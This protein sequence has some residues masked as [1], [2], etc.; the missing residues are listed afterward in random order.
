MR[1]CVVS[2]LM[3]LLVASVLS[4]GEL[5][6]VQMKDEVMVGDSALVLNGMGV[7]KKL[8]IKVYVAGLYLEERTGE[9]SQAVESEQAKQVVMHF[10]TDRATKEK[11]DDAWL[12]G[13]EANNPGEF[14]K[15][16]ERVKT[17][18]GY[19]GDM[20]EQ[21]QVVMSFVPG[22]GVEVSLNGTVKGTIEGDDFARA[23][24]RVWLGD[25][26]PTEDLKEGML[27]G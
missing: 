18:M 16:E 17:F 10:M 1:R 3:V 26:P 6:G 7:R 12:E 2:I 23:L 14:A 4:A 25:H 5:A 15:L 13:F 21:D 22:T 8:W 19:F 9:A 24:L 27:G 20:K 11:M